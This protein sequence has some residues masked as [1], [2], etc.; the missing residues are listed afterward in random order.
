MI[1]VLK[2]RMKLVDIKAIQFFFLS[3][4]SLLPFNDVNYPRIGTA[5]NGN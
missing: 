5:C 1:L 3:E 4:T 2:E